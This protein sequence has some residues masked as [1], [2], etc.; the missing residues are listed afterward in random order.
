MNPRPTVLAARAQEVTLLTNAGQVLALSNHPA[1]HSNVTARV[2]GHVTYALHNRPWV[3]FQDGTNGLI[4][5]YRGEVQSFTPGALIEVEG[6]VAAGQIAPLVHAARLTVLGPGALPEAVAADPARLNAGEHYARL[7]SVRGRV[8]DMMI[9][10]GNFSLRLH[11]GTNSF[12]AQMRAPKDFHLPTHW[13]D[14]EV[15]VRGMCWTAVDSR[16]QPYGF[17]AYAANTNQITFL[18][19]GS[20]DVFERAPLPLPELAGLNTILGLSEKTVKIHLGH[21]FEKLNVETRT[22]AAM[23]AME[24]LA[25]RKSGRE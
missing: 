9:S 2:R 22:A 15:E 20:A 25:G 18:S 14:A 1:R 11:D 7:V 3:Y 5:I 6:A 16:G 24:K 4:A 19:P 17:T 13:L 21:I 10:W 23:T 8:R 12:T